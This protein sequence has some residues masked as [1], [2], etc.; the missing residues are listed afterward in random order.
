[1]LSRGCRSRRRAPDRTRG[2][3]GKGGRLGG[4][5]T[6]EGAVGAEGAPQSVRQAELMVVVDGLRVGD[7]V[8]LLQMAVLDAPPEQALLEGVLALVCGV[9]LFFDVLPSEGPGAPILQLG[10]LD[11]TSDLPRMQTALST[12]VDFISEALAA[13]GTV[14]VHCHR[15]I[16][17]SATLAAYSV[18]S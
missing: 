7:A 4:R 8:A 16:S 9:L 11:S 5:G 13:G 1:M 3:W 15:G 14:L 17:R 2:V 6:L 10:L 12:G 18:V